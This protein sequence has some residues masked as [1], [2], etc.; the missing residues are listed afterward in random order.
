M[1]KT[2]LLVTLTIFIFYSFILPFYFILLN[3]EFWKLRIQWLAAVQYHNYC[4]II[5]GKRYDFKLRYSSHFTCTWLCAKSH[6]F[7]YFFFFILNIYFVYFNWT[8]VS[9]HIIIKW[10]KPFHQLW[11]LLL[12]KCNDN[13]LTSLVMDF[14][15]FS[16]FLFLYRII[17]YDIFFDIPKFF[18]T[19]LEN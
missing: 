9:C 3:R 1:L 12:T 15:S 19:N 11:W 17:R 2:F 13:N 4:L 10:Y 16:S 14:H 6:S 8:H 18:I 5:Q 7:A